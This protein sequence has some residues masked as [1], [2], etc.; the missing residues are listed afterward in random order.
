MTTTST[1]GFSSDDEARSARPVAPVDKGALVASRYRVDSILAW[2]GMGV[3]CR[4]DDL[5]REVPV[6]LKI[7]RSELATQSSF[8][9]RLMNEAHALGALRSEHVARF[10]DVGRLESAVP[11][12]VMEY[13]EGQTLDVVLK[14]RGPISIVDAVSY[15]LDASAALADAHANGVI[16]RDVKPE[17]LI[18][19]R[20]DTIVKL[21][22][23]GIAKMRS[24]AESLTRPG[25]SLGSPC[26][27]SPE[28]IICAEEVDGRTDIWS[29]GVVLYELLTGERP[30][31]GGSL[32]EICSRV[33]HAPIPAVRDKRPDVPPRLE[34]AIQRCLERNVTRRFQTI[35]EFRREIVPY[36][37][38]AAVRAPISEPPPSLSEREYAIPLRR[39]LSMT[40]AAAFVVALLAF[41][42]VRWSL[43]DASP[44]RDEVSAAEAD[45]TVVRART[46]KP[47]WVP[48][49]SAQGQ[50]AARATLPRS[51]R[52]IRGPAHPTS[53]A[54][55]HGRSVRL[56][57]AISA[58]EVQRR[59]LAYERYLVEHGLRRVGDVRIRVR[60]DGSTEVIE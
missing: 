54:P 10:F 51:S 8:D 36:A 27:M 59:K 11:Y 2:G 37:R 55:E 16:H 29:L 45:P 60:P 43:A 42:V 46:L 52:R 14:D 6:A 33:L 49:L 35:A 12:F 4:A 39:M 22:D 17:N 32:A 58:A 38:P 48:A 20:D 23:F 15:V 25:E 21:I 3:I 13:L 41:V 18:L 24:D 7:L 31:D 9:K 5:K 30:F 1:L 47:A 40:A 53:R 28:Q 19:C 44:Q 26:Y 50:P 57:K 34:A 56:E